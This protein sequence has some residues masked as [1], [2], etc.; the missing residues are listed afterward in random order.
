[1]LQIYSVHF[2][3]FFCSAC[4]LLSFAFIIHQRH[5]ELHSHTTGEQLFKVCLCFLHSHRRIKYVST[6]RDTNSLKV[7]ID[8]MRFPPMH[9][10]WT[11]RQKCLLPCF[12]R[13]HV[14]L[15]NYVASKRTSYM[16]TLNKKFIRTPLSRSLSLSLPS[17]F[18]FPLLRNLLLSFLVCQ[19]INSTRQFHLT[20]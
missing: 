13:C 18:L 12:I 10:L 16:Q 19:V 2:Q 17:S 4:F 5:I 15:A 20:A 14:A 6:F 11:N 9:I 3:S 1:M 8:G 7:Y